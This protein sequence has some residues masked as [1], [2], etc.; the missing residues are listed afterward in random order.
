MRLGIRAKQ[1]AGVTAIVGL[2]VIA[3][4]GLAVE[5]LSSFLLSESLSRGKMLGN[6]IFQRA[7]EVV[8]ASA[9]PYAG[10]R[11]DPGLRASSA[12]A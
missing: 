5:V 8:P 3:V 11:D 1:I 6:T 12:R 4:T 9:D 7:R 10:L 2:S